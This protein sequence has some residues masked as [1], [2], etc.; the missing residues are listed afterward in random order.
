MAAEIDTEIWDKEDEPVAYHGKKHPPEIVS[1]AIID[2]VVRRRHEV[3]IP[4]RSP[5]LVTARFL[6][7]F[8]PSLLRFGM[9]R[10]EP[11]PADVVAWLE[12]TRDGNAGPGQ[13]RRR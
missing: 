6:R 13:N 1:D 5:P 2:A 3:T 7:L 8:L 9:S 4:R 10:A 11:V 12:W